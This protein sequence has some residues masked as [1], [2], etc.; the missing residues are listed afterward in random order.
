[1]IFVHRGQC[2][3]AQLCVSDALKEEGQIG[4]P[5]RLIPVLLNLGNA[6]ASSG[7]HLETW[8]NY[9]ATHCFEIGDTAGEAEEHRCLTSPYERRKDHAFAMMCYEKGFDIHRKYQLPQPNEDYSLR[10]RLSAGASRRS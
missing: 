2:E 10:D 5:S 3:R 4:D 8:F 6:S 9:A 7:N 1:M